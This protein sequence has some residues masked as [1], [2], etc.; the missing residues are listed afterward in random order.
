MIQLSEKSALVHWYYSISEWQEFKKKEKSGIGALVYGIII[1]F[2]RLWGAKPKNT[3]I[4]Q[5]IV[6]NGVAKI[7][8]RSTIFQGKGK[9]LRKVDIKETKSINIVEIIFEK[10]TS[11]GTRFNEI[12]IPVPKGKLRE[13]VELQACLNLRRDVLSFFS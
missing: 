2:S 1:W 4:P 11:K 12:R 13:A 3:E 10:Q 6:W 9:W 8:G 7:N 5:T